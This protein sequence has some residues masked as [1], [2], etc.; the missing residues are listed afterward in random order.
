VFE[1]CA[2]VV[3]PVPAGLRVALRRR[4]LSRLRAAGAL[5]RLVADQAEAHAADNHR[6]DLPLAF[7]ALPEDLLN[8]QYDPLACAVGAGWDGAEILDVPVQLSWEGS[9][10]RMRERG[11]APALRTVTGVDAPRFEATWLETVVRASERGMP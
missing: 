10:L 9:M 6:S 2:P 5:G 4:H 7:P 3:V 1:R 8:F 11:G